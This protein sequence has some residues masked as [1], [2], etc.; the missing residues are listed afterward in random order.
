MGVKVSTGGA[1]GVL[2]GAAA[3]LPAGV[4]LG[5]AV[6]PPRGDGKLLPTWLGEPAGTLGVG[7][8]EPTTE[9]S[10]SASA[11]RPA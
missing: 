3:E 1:S 4:P 9:G 6:A 5:V 10:G 8:G 7:D 2:S 11:D